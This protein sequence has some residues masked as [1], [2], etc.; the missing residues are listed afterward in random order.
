[1]LPESVVTMK[2]SHLFIMLL[3]GNVLFYTFIGGTFDGLYY[4]T[5]GQGFALFMHWLMDR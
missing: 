5:A 1:M 2:H 4:T 3:I